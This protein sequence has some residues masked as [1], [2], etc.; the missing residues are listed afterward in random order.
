VYKRELSHD[1]LQSRRPFQWVQFIVSRAV[2]VFPILWLI[3]CINIPFWMDQTSDS[4]GILKKI[5]D[6]G[7][8]HDTYIYNRD[9]VIPICATLH[10]V[11]L[12][13]MREIYLNSVFVVHY[14]YYSL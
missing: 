3:L 11:A 9:R 12:N 8:R 5:P 6:P 4:Y 1:V 10:T 13:G 7:L 14:L 2:G